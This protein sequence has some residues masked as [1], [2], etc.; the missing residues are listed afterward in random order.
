[1]NTYTL[2]VL[3]FWCWRTLVGDLDD[4][5]WCWSSHGLLLWCLL[6][7]LWWWWRWWTAAWLWCWCSAR[8]F[9]VD[10]WLAFCLRQYVFHF[11]MFVANRCA[12]VYYLYY[13]GARVKSS[14]TIY[15]YALFV[16]FSI[17]LIIIQPLPCRSS[18]MQLV[19]KKRK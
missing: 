17:F 7:W 5:W 2:D 16:L 11:R 19:G 10:D 15:P 4:R 13:F 12:F 1:M 8:H 3:L 9:V 6:A 14:T 18:S